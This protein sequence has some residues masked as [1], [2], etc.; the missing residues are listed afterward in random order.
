MV[1][2]E[3]LIRLTWGGDA[4]CLGPELTVIQESCGR[5]NFSVYLSSLRPM[6]QDSDYVLLNLETPIC[7]T[8]PTTTESI[9]FNTPKEFAQALKDVGVDF[10]S[11]ANNHCLDM[12]T[13]GIDETIAS[14]DAIGLDHTGTYADKSRSDDVFVKEI[15]GV[16][17][18]IVCSTFG[19]NSQHNGVLLDSENE[20]RV[21]L[22]KK[23]VRPRRFKFRPEDGGAVA[24]NYL[25]DDVNPAAIDNPVNHP[26]VERICDKIRRARKLADVV[27][28]MP[29][30]GGQYN[31]GPA[32][33]AKY[34][35]RTM[36]RAGAD[37]V[38]AGH[39]HTSHRCELI[40]G[41]FCAY[42]LGNL[43]F[44]PEVG[45]YCPNTLAD[46]GVVLN[47]WFDKNT[48]KHVRTSF[49]IVKSVRADDGMTRVLPVTQLYAHEANLAR[50]EA[51]LMETEAV[52]NRFRG[53]ADSCLIEDSYG[54][55]DWI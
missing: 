29:H 7:P 6:F 49:S 25:P 8:K 53:S 32:E 9:R 23:Q 36:V 21:D 42:S 37:M 10:V 18:A 20:W 33:Y 19:T 11:T 40:D 27:I 55:K 15:K 28:A 26:F 46:Y 34:I 5:F 31:P 45:F 51:I 17:F 47:T 1:E 3:S 48:K 2:D 35:V 39:P 22:L 4:M 16:R 43:C 52:V 54:F 44:T 30:V 13:L 41:V 50:R 38:I 24:L 12:E 14:L